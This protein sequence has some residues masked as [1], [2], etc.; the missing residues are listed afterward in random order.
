MV[1][2]L[3]SKTSKQHIYYCRPTD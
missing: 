1:G 3:S 2:L